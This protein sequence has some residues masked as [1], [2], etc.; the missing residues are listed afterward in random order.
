MQF[1]LLCCYLVPP[2]PKY[3]PQQPILKHPQPV[4]LP[5]YERL[6]YY[7][8]SNNYMLILF[9]YLRYCHHHTQFIY[10]EI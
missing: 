10:R 2:R 7:L 1:P 8:P 3:S 5:Q 4:F 9:G 6:I